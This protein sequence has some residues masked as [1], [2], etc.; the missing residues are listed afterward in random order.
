MANISSDVEGHC[1]AD[2]ICLWQL[3]G[4]DD[5]KSH[6][7]RIQP[8]SAVTGQN[9]LKGF[10]WMIDNVASRVYYFGAA[11][12]GTVETGTSETKVLPDGTLQVQPIQ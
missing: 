6:A 4:L 2:F 11:R 3:L 10:D 9:L 12:S 5:I 8:C 7:W 1:V